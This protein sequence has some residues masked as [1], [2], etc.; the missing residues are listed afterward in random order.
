MLLQTQTFE[1]SQLEADLCYAISDPTRILILYAL[2][3]QPRNVTELTQ[4]LGINQPTVSRHLKILR[5]Q[6]LVQTTRKGVS[7]IYAL[8][9][10]RLINALDILRAILHDNIASKA[11]IVIAMQ[12]Q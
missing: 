6:G 1:I 11:N 9:D 5:N 3:E 8:A 7:V 4:D 12:S 2:K 10:K